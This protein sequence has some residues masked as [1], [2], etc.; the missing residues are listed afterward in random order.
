MNPINSPENP[1]DAAR[2]LILDRLSEQACVGAEDQRSRITNCIKTALESGVYNEQTIKQLII[3]TTKH[4]SSD[5]NIDALAQI[6]AERVTPKRWA[7][8]FCTCWHTR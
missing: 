3:N 2:M 5:D 7:S 6:L 4:A 1:I 8:R